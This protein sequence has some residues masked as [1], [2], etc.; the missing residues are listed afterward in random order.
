MKRSKHLILLPGLLCDAS[1]WRNQINAFR[2]VIDIIVGDLTRSETME[3]MAQQILSEAPPTFALAG[4]SMGGYVAQEIMRR[5]PQRVERL[6]FLN[7]NARA[8]SDEQR[9]IRAGLIDLAIIGKF[10]GVTPRLL[11]SLIHPSRMEDPAVAGVVLEMAER[12][13]QE[14]FKRQQKAILGRKDGREDLRAISVPTLIL[15][16]RD[17]LLCP[18]KVQEEMA[19]LIEKVKLVIID[20]CGHLS[21]LEQPDEVL[22]ELREWLGYC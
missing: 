18:P 3:E 16:G 19:E 21:P 5:A 10:K 22:A 17:D 8:D 9:R 1:L 14:V 12:M 20:H 11:P 15:S 6:A 7:T 13:G 2:D 4:L